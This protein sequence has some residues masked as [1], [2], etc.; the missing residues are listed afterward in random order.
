MDRKTLIIV[1]VIIILV[2][3]SAGLYFAFKKAP[4]GGVGGEFP[5]SGKPIG[6]GGPGT[7][8]GETNIPFPP[9]GG[10]TD[11]NRLFELHKVPV[12]GAGFIEDLASRSI[13]AR[14]IER[15]LGHIYETPLATL[16]GSRISNET[17]AGLGEA[18]WGNAGKS[19]VIRYVDDS[20]GSAIVTR[21]LNIDVSAASFATE[22]SESPANSFAVVEEMFLP[23][24]IP[25][26]ATNEDGAG[27]LFYLENSASSAVG[28]TATFTGALVTSIFNSIFTEWL[29]QFPNQNLVTLTSRP[30]ASIPGHFF[31]LDTKTGALTKIL[32]GINGLT[33]KTSR[34]GASVL[35]A[36]TKNDTIGLSVYNVA[37]KNTK[38]LS[39]KTLPEKCA[40]STREAEIVYC[41]VPQTLPTATYPDQWYQGIVSFSDNVWKINTETGDVE[42]IFNSPALDIINPVLSSDDSYLLFM[43]KI[44]GT[45]WVYRLADEVDRLPII[46]QVS[47][48]TSAVASVSTSTPAKTPSSATPAPTTTPRT[49]PQASNATE[50]MVQIR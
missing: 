22:D 42:K 34:A 43:N 20:M 19:V 17:R 1:A 50:G 29:P 30:S 18:L 47:T 2:L 23:D 6:G 9:P 28:S 49:I 7:G 44:T 5:G 4:S 35:Y 38:S 15:G 12:A 39:L 26:M 46:T 41:A 14:F 11:L 8:E 24:F 27:S 48:S 31:F 32:G 10:L 25:F 16:I 33:T 36:E 45:P 21:I 3:L 37:G 40:W 13:S